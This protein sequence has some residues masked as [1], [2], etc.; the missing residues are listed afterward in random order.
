M[1]ALGDHGWV[2]TASPNYGGP[3]DDKAV[4]WVGGV[5]GSEVGKTRWALGILDVD[6]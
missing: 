2:P 1:D 4:R 3:L 5:S 6:V